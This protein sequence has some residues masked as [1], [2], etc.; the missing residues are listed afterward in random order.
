MSIINYIAD[1]I[2]K[3]IFGKFIK[4]NLPSLHISNIIA[5]LKRLRDFSLGLIILLLIRARVIKLSSSDV[6]VLIAVAFIA[7]LAAKLNE[8]NKLKTANS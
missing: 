7:V 5:G 6:L 3:A 2:V 8:H 1:I 4:D